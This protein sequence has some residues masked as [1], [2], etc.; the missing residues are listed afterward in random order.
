[1]FS[2]I[3]LPLSVSLITFIL[4]DFSKFTRSAFSISCKILTAWLYVQSTSLAKILPYLFFAF[5][6]RATNIIAGFFLKNT[7]KISFLLNFKTPYFSTPL[8]LHLNY[9][10][11][12]SYLNL[13]VTKY[14]FIFM[15]DFLVYFCTI[16]V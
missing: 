15:F 1:M 5:L 9:I 16:L 8:F 10:D 4:P 12:H 3:L 13:C 7:S 2:A 14:I 6:R 11:Y